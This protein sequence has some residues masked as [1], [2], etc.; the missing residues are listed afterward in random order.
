M[1]WKR[2]ILPTLVRY[3]HRFRDNAWLR[4]SL[5][6]TE[7]KVFCLSMQR[8]GTTSVG[9]FLREFG[10]RCVG[11]SISE[12][13]DWSGAWYNGDY[14]SIFSS[15]DFRLANAYEDNPWWYPGFYGLLY[16]QFPGSKFILLERDPDT[17]FKSMVK[18]S[19]GNTLGRTKIHCKVYNRET[20]Y[21]ELLKH[22][23]FDERREN[24][25]GTEKTMK[26]TGRDEH[27]KAIYRNYN[28]AVKAFFKQQ[29]PEALYADRLDNPNK[30]RNLGEFLGITV[31]PDYARHEN[32]SSQRT[33]N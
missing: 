16:R 13:N 9:K 4:I 2:K 8:T 29:A 7:P 14:E 30:W 26:L 19:R 32:R 28:S 20:E 24:Q 22:D 33:R 25:L 18:H 1:T 10:Y 5:L 12:K 11:W 3:R 15:I 17:W 23:D 31:S 21:R 27:Y 6:E